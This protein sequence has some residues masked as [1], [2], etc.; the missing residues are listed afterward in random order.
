MLWLREKAVVDCVGVE[1]P[2]K[3]TNK[4]L[5]LV[6]SGGGGG[7]GGCCGQERRQWW[8]AWGWGD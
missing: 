7:G 4:S 6:S 2:D 8:V 1:R 5:R 3:P